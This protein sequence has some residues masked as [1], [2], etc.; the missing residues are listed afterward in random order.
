ME[1]SVRINFLKKQKNLLCILLPRVNITFDELSE[2]IKDLQTD[3]D[4]KLV[5]LYASDTDKQHSY[6]EQ[7]KS[8]G[9]KVLLL[10]HLSSVT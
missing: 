3:K 6:I 7:A 10:I 4:G 2:A 8:K 1:C 5:I 9:Y